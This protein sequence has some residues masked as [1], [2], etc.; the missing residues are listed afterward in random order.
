M[1]QQAVTDERQPWEHWQVEGTGAEAYERYLVPAIF[2]SWTDGLIKLADPRPGDRVLDVACGTGIV[3]RR[4]ASRVGDGGFLAGLD[5]NEGMLA[6]ARAT[7]ADVRPEIE[8]RQGNADSLP[9]A[10]DAFDLVFCQ[11]GLQFFTDPPAALREMWRVL[12]PSGRLAIN[13][14]RP[15]AHI[16]VYIPLAKALGHHVGSHAEAMMRSPFP[17]WEMDDLRDLVTEAGFHGAHARIQVDEVR[18][19][20]ATEFLWQE[21][22]SSPLAGAVTDLKAANREALVREVTKELRPYTDDDGIVFPI[23][24]H[25]VVAHR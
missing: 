20:S 19:P 13:V 5:L 2:T 14:C 9:F 17:G 1:T 22:A 15:I 12:V 6:V 23:Q 4:A 3:A 24:T 25:M 16:P 7:A 21:A 10:D 8:W 18:Y 11:Q